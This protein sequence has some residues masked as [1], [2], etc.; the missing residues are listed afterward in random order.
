MVALASVVFSREALTRRTLGALTLLPF[1]LLE[2]QA[3]A[4]PGAVWG[5]LFYLAWFRR[6]WGMCCFFSG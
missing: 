2:S 3:A 4:Y 6:H 5:L 1:I